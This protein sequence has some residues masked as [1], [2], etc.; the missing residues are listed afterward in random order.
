[1]TG[2][3]RLEV[4]W[5]QRKK[6]I[7]RRS[8]P[9]K[10]L[11]RM[12]FVLQSIHMKECPCYRSHTISSRHQRQVQVS[13]LFVILKPE[14]SSQ[15]GC[16]TEVR[17]RAAAKVSPSYYSTIS[18]TV[19]LSVLQWKWVIS[20][21]S[22]F[23]RTRA[24]MQIILYYNLYSRNIPEF[25]RS[26]FLDYTAPIAWVQDGDGDS[27]QRGWKI[28]NKRVFD[29]SSP[30]MR[31]ASQARL[32]F[33]VNTDNSKSDNPLDLILFGYWAWTKRSQFSCVSAAEE[34]VHCLGYLW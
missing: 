7:R 21:K 8:F 9:I 28:L 15:T 25:D 26:Y 31:I 34:H 33:S 6:V 30:R 12:L 27:I 3:D 10:G 14:Q 19:D 4:E 24:G 23:C 20:A 13:E 18:E 2:S 5:R 29:V 11:Q 1:M 17:L 16:R 32:C 22:G